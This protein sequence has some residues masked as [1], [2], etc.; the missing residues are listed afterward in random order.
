MP[1]VMTVLGPVDA[2]ALGTTITHEHLF[3]DL[4]CYLTP[5]KDAATAERYNAKVD[6]KNLHI[7]RRDPYGNK[8]NCILDDMDLVVRELDI[9]KQ[10]RRPDSGRRDP[11]RHRARCRS[12]RRS[13]AADRP[14]R[15]S[16]AAATISRR[17]I[18]PR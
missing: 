9:F 6:M 8:D 10:L 12:A 5:P 2:T 4:S 16:R 15:D 13:L 7:F 3:I 11:R 17:A 14:P 18:R 1:T